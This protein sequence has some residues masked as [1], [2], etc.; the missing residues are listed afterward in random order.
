PAFPAARVPFWST[1]APS[2]AVPGSWPCAAAGSSPALASAPVCVGA[3]AVA[4]DRVPATKVSTPDPEIPRCA[5][6]SRSAA[7]PDDHAFACAGLWP[8]SWSRRP[9]A[10]GAHTGPPYAR[11]TA[12]SRWP[13]LPLRLPPVA[14]H[15]ICPPRR[16]HDRA[17][18]PAPLLRSPCLA[19]TLAAHPDENHSL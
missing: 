2:S 18:V 12:C 3:A 8:G 1:T 9:N 16:R 5:S 7:H 19:Q 10:A 15:K 13:P 6:A 4:A 11:T 14:K 17:T